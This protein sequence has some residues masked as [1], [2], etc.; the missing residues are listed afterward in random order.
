VDALGHGEQHVGADGAVAG[1]TRYHDG[2]AFQ[3]GG[4]EGSP[5]V[6]SAAGRWESDM[7]RACLRG[8]SAAKMSWKT[9]SLM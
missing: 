6:A 9:S 1:G 7:I 8:R 2:M 3:A 5:S 4:P